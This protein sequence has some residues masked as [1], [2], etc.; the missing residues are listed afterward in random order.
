MTWCSRKVS[1]DFGVWLLRIAVV[2]W[3]QE[4]E[5]ELGQEQEMEGQ[6]QK[7]K[8]VVLEEAVSWEKPRAALR[9]R[10]HPEALV[11]NLSVFRCQL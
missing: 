2:D 3:E 4:L 8:A 9:T 10:W 11:S 5:P 7:P 6:E 1:R